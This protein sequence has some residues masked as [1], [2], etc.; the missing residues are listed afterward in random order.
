MNNSSDS[1][2]SATPMPIDTH[3]T[4]HEVN[5]TVAHILLPVM[6]IVGI[7]GMIS[8]LG[9]SV[10]FYVFAF[11]MPKGSQNF[12]IAS[13]SLI[14]LFSMLTGIPLAISDMRYR[15][16]FKALYLCKVAQFLNSTLI[17]A[18]IACLLVIAIDRY[19]KICRHTKTQMS[20]KSAS[21]FMWSIMLA[22]VISSSPC[23]F[24]Y[25]I[26]LI[27]TGEPGLLG[28]SC[29]V[30][31]EAAVHA[32]YLAMVAFFFF[33]FTT[34]LA[35]LYGAVGM[36]TRRR[37]QNVKLFARSATRRQ[38][39][40]PRMLL[41]DKPT[42]IGLT[43]T[44]VFVASFLPYLSILVTDTYQ[45]TYTISYKHPSFLAYN[46]FVRTY[47]LNAA[48]NPFIYGVLNIRFRQEVAKLVSNLCVFDF[49]GE[50][51]TSTSTNYDTS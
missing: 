28:T 25:G 9:N 39:S 40:W 15:F 26:A 46:L 4:I 44:V 51:F 23:I 20:A 29:Y 14:G 47:F 7:V 31:V 32:R 37:R 17:H 16:T 8:V 49:L 1:H 34:A 21:V 13:L 2:V 19:L 48:A 24:F 22:S 33:L 38:M 45:H 35:M 50:G 12:L 36:T 6:V 42:M 18:S 3:K 30:I 10:A 27:E 43:V 11:K 41:A 5:E